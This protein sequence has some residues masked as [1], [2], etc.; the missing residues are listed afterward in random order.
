MVHFIPPSQRRLALLAAQ[1]ETA[2]V[3]VLGGPGTGKSAL[4]KWL[5]RHG[6]RAGKPLVYAEPDL[7]LRLQIPRA[8]GGT[9]AIAE[10]SE[11]S[12]SEQMVLLN[13]LKTH[14]LPHAEDPSLPVLYSV[15]VIA[16][17]SHSLDGRAAGGLF[18]R[19]LLEKLSAYRLEVPPLVLRSAEFNDIVLGILG[20]ITH[21]L[22]KDHIRGVS[23]EAW[24]RLR[25]YEWPG[26]VRELRNVLR[27]AA[28]A[29]AGDRVELGDL[30]SF[31]HDRPDFRATRAEFEKIHRLPSL[32]GGAGAVGASSEFE[33]RPEV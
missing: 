16:T 7:P 29:A 20:E 13:F 9:L 12:L 19:E 8:Q 25:E 14:S 27:V 17:S 23:P 5:H 33:P 2:P 22:H 10:I 11:W 30:P 18:N 3:L 21:E 31:G 4:V 26:N 6:L 24:D 1:A 15:R 32:T 28:I